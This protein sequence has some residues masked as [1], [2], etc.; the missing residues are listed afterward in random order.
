MVQSASTHNAKITTEFNVI[1]L[2]AREFNIIEA[3]IHY[4][5]MAIYMISEGAS[6]HTVASN[7][8]T[9]SGIRKIG[10][11]VPLGLINT[12]PAAPTAD[13]AHQQDHQNKSRCDERRR[14]RARHHAMNLEAAGPP[15]D[16]KHD[17]HIGKQHPKA[18][19]L[20]NCPADN[21]WNPVTAYKAGRQDTDTCPFCGTA[22]G[23]NRHLYWKCQAFHH[24]RHKHPRVTE[25]NPDTK[26]IPE[27]LAAHGWA[28]A[29]HLDPTQPFW[30]DE[31][32]PC[33]KPNQG[34]CG[35]M[36]VAQLEHAF[37]GL[38][39]KKDTHKTTAAM[40]RQEEIPDITA[41][42]YLAQQLFTPN[43]DD[44][45]PIP[46]VKGAPPEKINVYTDGSVLHPNH[47]YA[48][49]GT[50]AVYHITGN[51]RP[52]LTEM[53]SARASNVK[54]TSRVSRCKAR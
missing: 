47:R 5:K 41:E 7:G 2:Y 39:G 1:S 17:G 8:K 34:I 48:A 25:L 36:T 52:Q 9:F 40:A 33:K 3:P 21:L 28:P 6:F 27:V 30:G 43:D 10:E 38:D 15:T 49:I 14:E 46:E 42:I 24:A 11:Q 19:L 13:E 26:I 37:C 35:V 45:E 51:Q 23:T 50:F 16:Y 29:L 18:Q 12:I 4:A 54:T 31:A 44:F 20:R 53:R 22:K 32:S